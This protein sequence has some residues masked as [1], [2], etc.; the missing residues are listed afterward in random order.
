MNLILFPL[1]STR[2]QRAILREK[3]RYG[4]PYKYNPRGDLLE[5]LSEQTGMTKE[6][7]Y[8]QLV[9]ERKFLLREQRLVSGLPV[10]GSASVREYIPVL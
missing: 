6:E 10:D 7:C 3:K 4:H 9:K 2:S 5:R 1:L 8:S